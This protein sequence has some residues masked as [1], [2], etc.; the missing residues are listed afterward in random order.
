MRGLER[1]LGDRLPVVWINVDERVGQRARE[2]YRNE[3]VPTV[4]LLDAEGQEVYRT[5]GKLP[6]VGQIRE[7]LAI[8]ERGADA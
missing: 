4:L 6:R 1:D 2:V 3:K 7:R 5:E 8:L